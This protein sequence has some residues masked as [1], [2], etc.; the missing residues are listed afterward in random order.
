MSMVVAGCIAGGG[1]IVSGII[2]MGASSSAAR[3]AGQEKA[4]L[5]AQLNSLEKSRQ[6]IVNPYG[7]FKD[8]SGLAT[9]LSGMISNPYA[10]LSVATKASEFQAEQADISLANTLDTLKE[11]GSSAGGATALAQMALQSK[12]GISADIEKQEVDNEK[13][14]AQGEAQMEQL[15]MGEAQRIQGIQISEAQRMQQAGA[16]GKEFMFEAKEARE[17]GKINRVAAQLDNAS[18][19]QQQAQSNYSGALTGMIGGLTSVAGS[20]MSASTPAATPTPT[21]SDRR[22]KKNI[23]KIGVSPKGLNIYSFEYIDNKYGIGV[24]QGVMS[25][26]VPF[27]TVIKDNDGYDKVNY[28]LLDVEFKQI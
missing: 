4:R 25:D 16:A 15:K 13:L 19:A 7:E 20:F 3:R 22:L 8:V 23:N 21:A 11:T 9:N 27:E 6:A 12:K 28:S 24:W 17:Q 14:K 2:G 26:E 18:M 5:T 10:N 1:S